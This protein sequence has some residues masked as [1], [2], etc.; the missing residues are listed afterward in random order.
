M[1]YMYD[2]PCDICGNLFRT[3]GSLHSYCD[4]CQDIQNTHP[5]LF[6]W[7]L[8]VVKNNLDKH[9]DKFMHEGY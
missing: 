4:S 7:V 1:P 5:K 3:D 6:K 2:M 9:E 8:K